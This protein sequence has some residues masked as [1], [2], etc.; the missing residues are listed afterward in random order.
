ML[1][2]LVQHSQFFLIL[3]HIFSQ[4]HVGFKNPEGH[5]GL[6]HEF[7]N[8]IDQLILIFAEPRGPESHKLSIIAIWNKGGEDW[9]IEPF[10]KE[11]AILSKMIDA[12][13]G[14]LQVAD[15]VYL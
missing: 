15:S 14:V 12:M 1:N 10:S 2:L 11:V 8:L 5:S 13:I 9:N 3:R 4:L 7:N 6:L